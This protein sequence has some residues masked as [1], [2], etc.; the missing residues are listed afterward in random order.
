MDQHMEPVFAYID[1]HSEEY[2]D[3]LKKFCSQPS[4]A[5]Q[6]LGMVE[7]AKEQQVDVIVATPHF[8]ATRSKIEDFV[9]KRATQRHEKF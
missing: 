2:I 1:A 5:A 4:V 7:M 9:K 6:H 8:Y 3:L